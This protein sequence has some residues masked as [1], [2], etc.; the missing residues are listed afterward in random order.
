MLKNSLSIIVLCL[1][2]LCV[3]AQPEIEWQKT[4]GGS[5]YDAAYCIAQT[6]DS[7]YIIAG[8][9]S[10]SDGDVSGNFG[11]LD[12]WIVKLDSTGSMLWQ[13]S[14]GDTIMESASSIQQTVDGGYIVCGYSSADDLND[15]PKRGTSDIVVIKLN[16]KGN[17]IWQKSLGGSNSEWPGTIQQTTDGGYIVGGSSKSKDGDVT[18]NHGDF[19]Y[20]IV[21]L[22]GSGNIV[23]QN[24][25]GG[26]ANDRLN[27][28][29]QTSDGGYIAAGSS[30]SKDK[31]VTGNHGRAD[32]WVIKI[33]NIGTLIWQKSLGG[34]LDDYAY[35]ITQTSDK[36]FIVA[37]YSGSYDGDLI[38]NTDPVKNWWVVKLDG[39]G[40]IEWKK[41]YGGNSNDEARSIV[42]TREG[43]YIIAGY[44]ASNDGDV[45][46]NHSLGNYDIWIL[47][48]NSTGILEWQKCLGGSDAEFA[49]SIV[50]TKDGGYA[51]AGFST[52]V[53]GDVSHN[54]G[55]DDY[56][57]VKLS[58]TLVGVNELEEQS[59]LRL[60]PNPANYQL[61]IKTD[62]K[63]IGS[64]YTVL[65][66]MGQ[67][68]LSGKINSDNTLLEVGSFPSGIYFVQIQSKDGSSVS[69]FIKE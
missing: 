20:W 63:L 53:D 8:V 68:V 5:D 58:G 56:W 31:D 1:T 19:D 60:Y 37:G 10:S 32:Y 38:G 36:G 42:Q 65:N 11:Y 64:N 7:G 35:S 59:Q 51:V 45:S 22:D 57:I 52:S 55:K 39:L 47:K 54:K 49:F 24:S 15:I 46:G 14:L 21:K 30:N 33:D 17:I 23:W 67:T 6:T 2:M 34:S 29:Q 26:T 9:T 44:T 27:S 13:K 40:N 18:R 50:Q 4:F 12:I 25:Y 3:Q 69:G 28:I 43:G 16:S 61:T 41:T 48:I 62:E 66:I